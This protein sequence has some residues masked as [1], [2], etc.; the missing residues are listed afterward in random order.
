[1]VHTNGSISTPLTSLTPGNI[2]TIVLWY[3]KHNGTFFC[4]INIKVE[5]GSWLDE[6]WTAT[7][8]GS[9]NWL[10]KCVSFTAQATSTTLEFI[11]T[12]PNPCCGAL[13]DD[14]TMFCCTP[15]IEAPVFF[16]HLIL[17]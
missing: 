3:A 5:N 7:N 4:N 9:S 17:L 10:Q 11:G 14:L 13:I 2:Y 12:S 6:T 16:K 1:M 15:D 8:T